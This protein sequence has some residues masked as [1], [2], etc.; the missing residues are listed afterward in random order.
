MIV[1]MGE[2]HSDIIEVA[3]R[4][5]ALKAESIPINLLVPIEG[6]VLVSQE[7]R[8][9]PDF[10]FKG[11][12]FVQVFE[13]IVGDQGGCRAG[14]AFAFDGS[15]GVISSKFFIFTGVFKR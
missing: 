1:G 6:N 2:E 14:A 11:S 5:R 4:L 7:S 8:P 9:D 3:R 13:P 12:M 15:D 10:Y